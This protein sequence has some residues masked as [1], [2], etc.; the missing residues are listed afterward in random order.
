MTMVDAM[1]DIN[2]GIDNDDLIE[3]ARTDADADADALGRLYELH[4]DRIFRFCVYRLFNKEIAEDI[5]SIV[6]L[7]V[8]RGIRSFTGRTEEDFRNWLYAIA[9]NQANAYIRKTSRREQILKKVVPSVRDSERAGDSDVID[10]PTLYQ[11]VL[12]LKPEHQTIVTL[13]FFEI[14]LHRILSKLRKSLQ[15]VFDGEV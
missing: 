14:T 2:Q 8:A 9:V 13:R 5:T 6:F 7:E 10:W 12:Q 11:A 3:R 15:S 4:Y 1:A